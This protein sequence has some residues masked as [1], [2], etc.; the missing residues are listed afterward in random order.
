MQHPV[1]GFVGAEEFEH[2]VGICHMAIHAN[3]ERSR[4]PAAVETRWS[5][6]TGAEVAQAPGARPHDE[7]GGA[8]LLVKDNAVISGIGFGQHR[9]LPEPLQSNRPPSTITPPMA[10]PW[11]PI[12]LVVEF[13]TISAPSSIGRLR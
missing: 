11:P 8:E 6:K 13:I 10:M 7:G 9:K 12:H 1:D 2:R 3:A 5:A 4:R